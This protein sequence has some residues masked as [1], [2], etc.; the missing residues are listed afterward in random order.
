MD[1]LP[2]V[3][4]DVE[5]GDVPATGNTGCCGR[6]DGE[7]IRHPGALDGFQLSRADAEA[8]IMSARLQAGWVSEEDLAGEPEDAEDGEEAPVE[9]T[10]D[11]ELVSQPAD[12]S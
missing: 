12:A 2:C 11:A 6:K 10:G 3:K 7:V 9:D 4:S 5:G 1:C 8:M